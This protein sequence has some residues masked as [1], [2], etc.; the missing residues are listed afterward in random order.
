MWCSLGT[1]ILLQFIM[2][3]IYPLVGHD[4]KVHLNWLSQFPGLFRDGLLYPRWMPDSFWGFGSPAFYFYPPMTYWCGSLISYIFPSPIAIYQVLGLI[5]TIA[6]VG[7][8][9]LYLRSF[10]ENTNSALIGAVMYGVFPYRLLDIYLRNA[11]SE[12]L[13]LIFLPIVLL[14]IEE[15]V[16]STSPDRKFLM[17]SVFLCACGWA[18]MFLTNIPVSAIAIYVIPVYSII[19]ASE[20]KNYS[21]L[22][23]PLIGALIGAAIAAIYLLPISQFTSAIALSSLWDKQYT[24]SNWGYSIV[25]LLNG[26]Y[27]FNYTGMIITLASGAWVCYRLIIKRN[28]E[29]NKNILIAV[30]VI[31]IPSLVL[32]IPYLLNPLWDTLPLFRLIQFSYRWNIIIVLASAVYC[33]KYLFFSEQKHIRWFISILSSVTIL[34]AVG[35]FVTTGGWEW[36]HTIFSRHIDPPEYLPSTADKDFIRAEKMLEEH[37]MDELI[38]SKN[39]TTAFHIFSVTSESLRFMK[40]KTQTD[41]PVVFHRMYFPAW[42]L[43]TIEGVEIAITSDSLGRINAILPAA[44]AEYRL[45]LEETQAEKTGKIISLAGLSLLA[46]TLLL[47]ISWR[48]PKAS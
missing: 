33:A 32:Q 28:E 21:R 13:A 45:A 15:A 14:S 46:I 37:E 6:S 7:T 43:L 19:R 23:F 44:V 4:A 1:V 27:R 3:F 11:I 30:L 20:K 47:T 31:L 2:P 5:A 10:V 24:V 26:S 39:E 41:I 34:I 12:H 18:G 38:S 40:E 9:Y 36:D 22:V 48:N 16:T 17:R 8:C 42:H 29:F 25:E 35:F